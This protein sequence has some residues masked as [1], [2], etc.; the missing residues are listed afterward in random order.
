MPTRSNSQPLIRRTQLVRLGRLLDMLYRPAEIAE[1]LGLSVDTIYRTYIH[2]GLPHTRDAGGE[3]W[4]HGPACS[5]WICAQF[6]VRRK[7]H[8]MPADHAWCIRCKIP[9]PLVD[10]TARPLG[11]K[12]ILLQATCPRCGRT[13][14][15]IQR[16]PPSPVGEGPGVR[17]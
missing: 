17:S 9:A 6:K 5:E 10:A 16:T 7:H 13:I 4:I 15:R 3:I 14:N 11:S 2:N 8:P 1:E 12:R